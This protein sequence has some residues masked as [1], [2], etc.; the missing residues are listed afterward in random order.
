MD[1]RQ[2]RYFLAVAEDLHFTKAADRMHVVQ[3]ALSAQIKLL[4]DH[5]GVRLFA[6]RKRS[7]VALTDAGQL[8]LPEARR[9][10]E[11]LAK[12]EIVGRR[13]GRGE[14]G[15]VEVGYV[16]SA[17]FSGVLPE[18]LAAFRASSGDVS[19][20]LS[21]M[22]TPKQL[23]AIAEGRLDV[24]F[25]RPR[26]AYPDGV[27]AKTVRQEKLLL[28][29]PNGHPLVDDINQH[30]F[31]DQTFIIPQF[32]ESGGFTEHVAHLLQTLSARADNILRVRDFLTALS[33]VGGR[34][35]IAL[36]PESLKAVAIPNVLYR[37][38]PAYERRV[39]LCLAHRAGEESPAVRAF[40]A[41]CCGQMASVAGS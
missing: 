17:T 3:S 21:E 34:Y 39:D 37:S 19:V 13:A 6:R 29:F 32:D 33:L 18:T 11:Q 27:V 5:L 22:E 26:P 23:A 38:I 2:L 35:G 36:V 40:I 9:V 8:F 10:L 28:A 24:G 16:A 15:H 31:V 12:A 20:R 7:S 41:T 4:E 14:L 30:A 25:V 1:I